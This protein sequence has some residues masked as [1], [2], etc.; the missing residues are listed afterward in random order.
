[1][2]RRNVSEG[3][4]K[5]RVC[6]KQFCYERDLEVHNFIHSSSTVACQNCGKQFKDIQHLRRHEQRNLLNCRTSD[7]IPY[8][9]RPSGK[10][11]KKDGKRVGTSY[12]SSLYDLGDLGYDPN[13]RVTDSGDLNNAAGSQFPQG[14]VDK[15][16]EQ[17]NTSS[18]INK[19][20]DAE[21]ANSNRNENLSAPSN[22]ENAPGTVPQTQLFSCHLCHRQFTD[23][24]Q[25]WT[26]QISYCDGNYYHTT[27]HIAASNVAKGIPEYEKQ[28]ETPSEAIKQE[29]YNK[30]IQEYTSKGYPVNQDMSNRAQEYASKGYSVM[31]DPMYNN[32]LWGQPTTEPTPTPAPKPPPQENTRGYDTPHDS[33]SDSE[34]NDNESNSDDSTVNLPAPKVLKVKLKGVVKVK[35]EIISPDR[36]KTKS[37]P[38]D[39]NQFPTSNGDSEKVAVKPDPDDFKSENFGNDVKNE[40]VTPPNPKGEQQQH[41]CVECGKSFKTKR[42]LGVHRRNAHIEPTIPCHVCGKLFNQRRALRKHLVSHSDLQEFE[43]EICNG[44]FKSKE[45]LRRHRNI[46]TKEKKYICPVCNKNF[47]Q[48]SSLAEHKRMHTGEFVYQCSYCSQR[49][50]YKSNLRRHERMHVGGSFICEICGNEFNTPDNLREHKRYSHLVGVSDKKMFSCDICGKKMSSK[51]HFERHLTTHFD[52]RQIECDICHKMFKTKNCLRQHKN[53]VHL[54]TRNP[55]MANRMDAT[56]D[57]GTELPKTTPVDPIAHYASQF[58]ENL[59]R[60]DRMRDPTSPAG[61]FDSG[62]AKSATMADQMSSPTSPVGPYGSGLAQNLTKPDQIPGPGPTSPAGPFDSGLAQNLIMPGRMSSYQ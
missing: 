58:A 41:L 30:R 43:C 34:P 14:Q 24:Y 33:D 45:N 35:R 40:S 29:D 22:Q 10:K 7:S 59:T 42:Y 55:T 49:F 25:L 50:L 31:N 5:C 61:S 23:R 56:Y 57:A 32:L 3:F 28:Q 9:P 47:N 15:P 12:D 54:K 8:V 26:H 38:F 17:D 37:E 11:R 48:A 1:M 13:F 44:K 4:F 21:S 60:S 52:I 27:P 53:V 20:T 16:A 51:Y 19:N 46:H 18:N 2:E 36:S 62:L 6:D 39:E